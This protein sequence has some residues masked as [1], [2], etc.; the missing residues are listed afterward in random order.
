MTEP[1]YISPIMLA[2][3]SRDWNGSVDDHGRIVR[4]GDAGWFVNVWGESDIN[5]PHGPGQF[6]VWQDTGEV[7]SN[8]YYGPEVRC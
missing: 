8:V 7:F 5:P 4:R 3:S 6:N 1:L 2:I